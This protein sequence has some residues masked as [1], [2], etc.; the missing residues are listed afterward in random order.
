MAHLEFPLFEGQLLKLQ[1][2]QKKRLQIL[3]SIENS[4]KTKKKK[5]KQDL[6]KFQQLDKEVKFF[7]H[8][9][10]ISLL[11]KCK[12]ES[13]LNQKRRVYDHNLDRNFFHL[14]PEFFL[15][16]YILKHLRNFQLMHQE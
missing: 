6:I 9:I 5:E 14:R 3:N 13:E 11:K 12:R 16:F 10:Y 15:G 2:K 8:N 4:Q 7:H 1:V